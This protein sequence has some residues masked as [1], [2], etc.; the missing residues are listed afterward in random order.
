M[1]V[2]L[3]VRPAAGLFVFFG[4]IVPLWPVLFLVAPGL[5]RNICP[6]AATNQMPRFFGF[7][8]ALEP[9]DW[10]RNR[11]YLIAM[12]LFFG[13]AGA[14]LAGLDRSGPA[15]GVVLAVILRRHSRV[16]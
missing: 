4:V 16:A 10:L 13:I 3:F 6:L 2:T 9:P 12:A 15:M 11:G 1:V 5:W 8:R 7:S 14:R